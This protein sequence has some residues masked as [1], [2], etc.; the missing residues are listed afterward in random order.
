MIQNNGTNNIA[1][2]EPTV[3][4]A[5]G[6]EA[7]VAE[8]QPGKL[9]TLTVTFPQ[10]FELPQN[11]PVELTVKSTHPRYPVI[12]VPIAQLPHTT[13]TPIAHPTIVPVV[14]APPTPGAAAPAPA[15]TSA[16]RPPTQ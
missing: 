9:F 8:S 16:A 11:G 13:I 3:A 2:S 10:G 12:K 4:A 6:V 5:K 1:L 14:P 7:Q 15:T